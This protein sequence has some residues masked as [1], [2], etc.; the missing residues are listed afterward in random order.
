M[1]FRWDIGLLTFFTASLILGFFLSVQLQVFG[2]K[3]RLESMNPNE[4]SVL[5]T[6]LNSEVTELKAYKQELQLKIKEYADVAGGNR[7]LL[8]N[9]KEEIR[10]LMII[11]GVGSVEGEGIEIKLEDQHDNLQTLDLV[12]LVNELRAAGAVAISID[13]IRITFNT[14]ILKVNGGFIVEGK[15][16]GSPYF[17]VATGNKET[18]YSAITFPG[19][20]ADSLENI[21]GVS[22]MIEKK[23]RVYIPSSSNVKFKWVNRVENR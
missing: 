12:D 15:E 21:D 1:K 13:N 23:D 11:S 16:I 8:E 4:L 19:G 7:K 6:N 22:I 20:I 10:N 5:Y 3:G 2:E 9:M 17:V 18:L 14:G